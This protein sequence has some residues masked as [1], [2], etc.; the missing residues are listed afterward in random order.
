MGWETKD[1]ST[2][3]G[4][5]F[6]VFIGD[7]TR[8]P[9]ILTEGETVPDDDAHLVMEIPEEY[10]NSFDNDILASLRD[11]AGVSTF[12]LHPFILETEKVSKSFGLVES[13]LSREDCDFM[14]TQ[15]QIYPQRIK[16]KEFPRFV[17]LDL[18]I[19]G[20]SAGVACGY[21]S[22]FKRVER[23]DDLVEMQPII[24]YDKCVWEIKD[25]STFSGT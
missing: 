25:K 11:I 2:F 21:V 15:L 5:W 10:R 19:T 14:A 12:A 23:G 18:A 20:D 8:K 3:S 16:H 24:V 22:G 1:K 9:R 7:E 6:K 13:I 4:T 17:H